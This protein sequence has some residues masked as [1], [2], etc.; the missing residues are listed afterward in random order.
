MRFIKQE[1]K[2]FVF[3]RKCF[4][5]FAVQIMLYDSRLQV[6]GDSCVQ[7]SFNIIRSNVNVIASVEDQHKAN[8]SCFIASVQRLPALGPGMA[9]NINFIGRDL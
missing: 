9:S 4:I 5:A 2:G 1:V 3:A 7:D 8:I 6:I